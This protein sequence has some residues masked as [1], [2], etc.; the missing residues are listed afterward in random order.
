MFLFFA[1]SSSPTPTDTSTTKDAVQDTSLSNTDT[2]DLED[3]LER[4][5]LL[6]TL[7]LNHGLDTGSILVPNINQPQWSTH[8]EPRL[9]L[10]STHLPLV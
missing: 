2:S 3:T 4:M 7:I 9:S 6:K 5:V 8:R 1:C 10:N